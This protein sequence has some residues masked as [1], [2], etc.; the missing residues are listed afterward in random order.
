MEKEIITKFPDIIRKSG[1]EVESSLVGLRGYLFEG[2]N[3]SQLVFW[4]CDAEV[5][6]PLDQHDFDE[7]CL[8]VEGICKQ[9]VEKKTTVLKKGDEIVI[10]AGKAH[11]AIMGPHYRAIDYFA[12]LRCNYKK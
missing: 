4:E 9:T 1:F 10:P 12:G 5:K 6:V 2:K 3:G 8:V 7:Y 11:S